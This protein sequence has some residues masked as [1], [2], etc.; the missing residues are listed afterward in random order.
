[1][2]YITGVYDEH[3]MN[4]LHAI[5]K[6]GD[7]LFASTEWEHLVLVYEYLTFHSK[8]NTIENCSISNCTNGIYLNRT[9]NS[10]IEYCS[11]NSNNYGVYFDVYSNYNTLTNNILCSNSIYDIY[12]GYSNIGDENK[13]DSCYNYNDTGTINC[14]Y[15][16]AA[17]A[18]NP[19][20]ITSGDR[21]LFCNWTSDTTFS[22]IAV[23]LTNCTDFFYYNSTSQL[24]IFY[25]INRTI[26]ADTVIHKHAAIFV[27]FNATTT[28]NCNV[29]APE[30]IIIPANVYYYT[31]LRESGAKTL[32]E[33]NAAITS[34][35]CVITDLY[36]WNSTAG[37]YTNTGSYSILP[38]EGF[39]IYATTGCFWDGAV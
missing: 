1:M 21:A 15:P 37:A 29:L 8:D 11:L 31:A 32:T 19:I 34:D 38:N 14:T 33:I 26:N 12:D 28:V 23:N 18:T 6:S 5:E 13:C 27:H 30:T 4:H 9:D 7:Y 25:N 35:G 20:T 3:G 24:W 16:C 22:S 10:T 36:A 2:T 17:A 39:A